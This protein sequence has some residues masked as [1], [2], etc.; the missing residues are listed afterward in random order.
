MRIQYVF[1]IALLWLLLSCGSDSSNDN[2]PT[3]QRDNGLCENLELN[4]GQTFDASIYQ[5]PGIHLLVMGDTGTGS[6]QQKHAAQLFEDFHLNYP[7]DAIIHTGDVF[8]P[9]GISSSDHPYTQT[10][11]K[12]IYFDKAYGQLPWYMVAGNHDYDGSISALK[13]FFAEYD[14]LIYPNNY[15]HQQISIEGIN[16]ELVALDTDPVIKGV[17]QAE[18]ISWLADT[19]ATVNT[20]ESVVFVFGHHP[21]YSNGSHGNND[22]LLGIFYDMLKEYQAELYLAGHDH[23]L[24][25][26]VKGKLPQF[27][28]SGAAGK[29]LRDI[30]CGKDS[31]YARSEAGGFAL[32]VQ[33]ENIWIIPLV[34][35]NPDYMFTLSH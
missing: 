22:A 13:G 9:D 16:L 24:E 14:H 30:D 12:D 35:S 8:Y 33:Q 10:R 31:V 2:L 19:F 3:K 29:T 1:V 4:Q 15:Y 32:Y 17:V 27:V 18:Q 5:Q 25:Y 20:Q 23:S 7:F 21:M 34:N 6:D 11:F 28:I 26:L